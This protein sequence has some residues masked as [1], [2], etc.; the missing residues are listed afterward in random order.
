MG[1]KKRRGERRR[2][3]EKERRMEGAKSKKGREVEGRQNTRTSI[4]KLL[5]MADLLPTN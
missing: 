5:T 4:Q 2:R 1:E 3:K